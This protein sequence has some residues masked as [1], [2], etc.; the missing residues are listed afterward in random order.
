MEKQ[1]IYS[2]IEHTVEKWSAWKQKVCSNGQ[3][4]NDVLTFGSF[5]FMIWFMYVAMK[6]ILIF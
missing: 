3:L 5:A 2:W 1:I 6:P 4:C